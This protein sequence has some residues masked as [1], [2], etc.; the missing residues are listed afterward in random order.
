MDQRQQGLEIKFF[1]VSLSTRSTEST[2][3]VAVSDRQNDWRKVLSMPILLDIQN[4]KKTPSVKPGT[5][6]A[7][8][9]E[10]QT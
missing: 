4:D 1:I 2:R 8:P 9:S 3:A 6:Q 10:I 5:P 7:L